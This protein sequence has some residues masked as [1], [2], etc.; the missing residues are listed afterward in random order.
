MIALTAKKRF[1]DMLANSGEA[2]TPSG[3]MRS[4]QAFQLDQKLWGG[5]SERALREITQLYRLRT[6]PIG[7]RIGAAWTL[8]RWHEYAKR[9]EKALSWVSAT[10]A[11]AG[12]P[13][14]TPM[15]AL[16][17][18]RCLVALGRSDEAR[19]VLDRCMAAYDF[20]LPNICLAYANTFASGG[21]EESERLSWINRVFE[22][23]G[24]AP[25]AKARPNEPLTLENLSAPATPDGPADGGPTVSVIVPVHNAFATIETAILGLVRQTWPKIEIIA[26]DDCSVDG[27]WDALSALAEQYNSIRPIR[28][29][30]NYGVYAARNTGLTA[31]SGDLI[32]THDGDD[33]S[34]PQKIEAQVRFMAQSDAQASRLHWSRTTDDL[35]FV[36]VW[37]SRD[38]LIVPDFSSLM[39]RREVRE[40]LGA[41]DRVRA[42]ADNEFVDRLKATFG[43]DAV[44]E[45]RPDVPLAFGRMLA[46]SL[47]ASSGTHVDTL[48]H[49]V[50]RDYRE[51]ADRWYRKAKRP[52]DLRLDPKAA[53]RPF[54]APPALLPE[55]PARPEYD[56]LVVADS[57]AGSH[58]WATTMDY[59]QRQIGKQKPVAFFQWAEFARATEPINAAIGSLADAGRLN[60]ISAGEELKAKTVLIGDPAILEDMIDRPPKV[61]FQQLLVNTTTQT[62]RD[63]R[64]RNKE[65]RQRCE[66]RAAE[67]L[68]QGRSVATHSSGMTHH[69]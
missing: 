62:R 1:V 49:G 53:E 10:H 41:W 47:T 16:L 54:P 19:M 31:A 46:T 9:F 58:A 48:W 51:A 52:D 18:S 36:N 66:A 38:K 60:V 27:T 3:R 65:Q 40:R 69:K 13:I 26:V 64:L 33:W 45:H 59:M 34:H 21:T 50:R 23:A 39:F 14:V 57:N 4:V 8:A 11:L 15:I 43:P 2:S 20:F 29:D 5:F 22:A 17:E 24:F 42:A 7:E 61:E 28:H 44:V 63:R 68:W 55:R 67:G 35:E 32:T 30:R 37:R 12:S 6:A 25:I 56:L